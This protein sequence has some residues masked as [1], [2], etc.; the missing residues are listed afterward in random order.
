MGAEFQEDTQSRGGGVTGRHP[1]LRAGLIFVL[2]LGAFYAIGTSGFA[3]GS[4]RRAYL[5]FMASTTRSIL[6]LTEQD[7]TG[8]GVVIRAGDFSVQVG[9]ECDAL[10]L[11]AV[12][13]AAVAASPLPVRARI[14]GV[15]VGS[16]VLLVI[17]LGRVVSLC[18]IGIYLPS[19]FDIVHLDVWHTLLVVLAVACWAVWVRWATRSWMPREDVHS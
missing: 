8:A 6:A 19:I 12:F 5:S 15:I 9:E 11:I 10:Y 7:V 17:N 2:L 13:I 14:T 4:G 18:F 3:Q 1:L 16:L